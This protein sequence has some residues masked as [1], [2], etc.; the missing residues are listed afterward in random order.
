MEIKGLD[1]VEELKRLLRTREWIAV[2]PTTFK[3]IQAFLGLEKD[4]YKTF[5][6]VVSSSK[7]SE[8]KI[9]SRVFLVKKTEEVKLFI[10]NLIVGDISEDTLNKM[11]AVDI[12]FFTNSLDISCPKDDK[13]LEKTINKIEESIYE[14]I[15]Y[16]ISSLVSDNSWFN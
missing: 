1:N 7:E 14:S 8:N 2:L 13:E 10:K 4:D 9:Y 12:D 3:I 16:F 6:W 5:T 15:D 11:I